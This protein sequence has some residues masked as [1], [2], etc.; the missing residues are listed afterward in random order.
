MGAN[1]WVLE[2]VKFLTESGEDPDVTWNKTQLYSLDG[3]NY[4]KYKHIGYMRIRFKTKKEACDYYDHYNP[5]MRKLNAH[6]NYRSDWDPET[7]LLYIVRKDYFLN[8]IIE[9]WGEKPML[10]DHIHA[11]CPCS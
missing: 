8:S 4:G 1:S 6:N 7:K 9:N 11:P 2:V 3:V 10:E 5:H